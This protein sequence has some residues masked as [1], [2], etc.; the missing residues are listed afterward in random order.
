MKMLFSCSNVH[1]FS[2]LL[3]SFKYFYVKMK[4]YYLPKEVLFVAVCTNSKSVMM[5]CMRS[6]AF[7]WKKR[8][9]I[10]IIAG[11]FKHIDLR[12][13]SPEFHQHVHIPNSGKIITLDNVYMNVPVFRFWS[14]RPYITTSAVY[15]LSADLKKGH[16]IS[17]NC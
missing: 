4:T 15:L 2:L 12:T 11:D 6:T 10:L 16:T 14:V 8:D 9:D 3:Q 17:K 7:T 13:V 5:N 1:Q